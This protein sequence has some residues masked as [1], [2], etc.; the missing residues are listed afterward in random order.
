MTVEVQRRIIIF[1]FQFF[2]G[3]N[4]EHGNKHVSHFFTHERKTPS[5]HV[6][7]VG[8]PVWVWRAVKLADIHHIVFVLEHRSFVVVYIK[9]IRRRKD[10]HDRWK[11]GDFGLAV[12]AVT[13][14]LSFM[15]SDYR[16][17]VVSFQELACSLIRKKV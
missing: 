5:K 4:V 14:I 15:G 9:I 8:Q 10:G 2:F 11:S 6:H 7:K 16:E 3:A 13:G 17:K 1:F 12:H